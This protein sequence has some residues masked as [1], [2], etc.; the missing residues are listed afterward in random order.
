MM[1]A[2]DGSLLKVGCGM[3]KRIIQQRVGLNMRLS[4]LMEIQHLGVLVKKKINTLG[5]KSQMAQMLIV[6]GTN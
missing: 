5:K 3:R 4:C 1:V 2:C 6:D